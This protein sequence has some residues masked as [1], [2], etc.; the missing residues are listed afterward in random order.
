MPPRALTRLKVLPLAERRS[1][2][3]LDELLVE[4]ANEPPP[5]S[6]AR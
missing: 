5:V 2:T 6:D 4:P 1:L 3:T